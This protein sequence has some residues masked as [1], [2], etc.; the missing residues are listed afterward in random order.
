MS[1]P[2]HDPRTSDRPGRDAARPVAIVASLGFFVALAVF[3][4]W[5]LAS[6]PGVLSRN[7]N[8][9]AILHEWI[10]AWVPHQIV[11]HPLHLFD[12]NIFYPDR[13]TLA[14]SDHLFLQSML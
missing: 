10:M 14:Y 6:R 1:L 8:G 7:D 4:T 13:Y 11:R 3:H 9:D 12:A 5:P 2:P